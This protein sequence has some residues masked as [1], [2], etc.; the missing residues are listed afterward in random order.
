MLIDRGSNGKSC[1]RHPVPH[2]NTQAAEFGQCFERVFLG[3]VVTAVNGAP[4]FERRGC[5]KPAQRRLF[6]E[7]C[8]LHLYDILFAQ[9]D[10]FRLEGFQLF[11]RKPHQFRAA[12][13]RISPIM[14]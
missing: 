3:R 9:Q 7:G 1:S 13:A 8:R 4:S 14:P 11:A 10:E 6:V 5:E 12:A 2:G